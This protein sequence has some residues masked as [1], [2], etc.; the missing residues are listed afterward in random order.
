M[1]LGIEDFGGYEIVEA[2]WLWWMIIE[3]FWLWRRLWW[4]VVVRVVVRVED[5]GC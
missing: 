4:L 3:A 1:L 5:G 2:F